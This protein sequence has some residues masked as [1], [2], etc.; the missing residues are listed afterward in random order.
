LATAESAVNV[1]LL[2]D[3]Q[4]AAINSG[5][6]DEELV[7]RVQQGDQE[8]FGVLA[9]RH[10]KNVYWVVEGILHNQADSEEVLQEAFLKAF[11]HIRDF[12]GDSRFATWLIRI[13][14]NEAHMR[15]RKYKPGRYD[16]I[17]E[18]PDGDREFRP[19]ELTDWRPNPEETFAKEELAGLLNKGIQSLPSL[20]RQIFLL[21]DVQHLSTEEA[22][23]ALGLTIPAAKTR[24]LRA[25]LMMREFLAPHFKT[26]WN[27]RLPG[28]LENSGRMNP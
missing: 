16:S 26:G 28:N 18:E 19:R 23:Q 7:R 10:H 22:A 4:V 21:R 25:R 6:G 12:R 5:T 17:D 1:E 2:M 14:I 9:E 13:A 3:Q 27:V 20:Y 11:D 24:L 8:A 15:L